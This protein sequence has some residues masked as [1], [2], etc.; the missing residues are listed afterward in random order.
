MSSDTTF[1]PRILRTRGLVPLLALM[2]LVMTGNGMVAPVL[3]LYAQQFGVSGAMVGM[4]ITLFGLGRLVANMPAGILSERHG[5]RL[6]L[7]LGPAII[8]IGALGAAVTASFAAVLAWRFVQGVG[9]GVYMTVSATVLIHLARR[10]ERGRALAI[11]Q[12]SLLLGAGIGPAIGGFLA[13]RWGL[14]MPFWAFAA[15]GLAGFLFALLVFE[16][17]EAPVEEEAAPHQGATSIGGLLMQLPFLVLCFITFGTFFTRTGSQWVTI[18]LIGKETFGLSVDVIGVALSVTSVA[19]FLMLPIVGP[20][21]DWVGARQVTVYS[22]LLTGLALALIALSHSEF[23]FWISMVLLG[24]AAG[25]NGP[26]VAAALADLVPR[27]LYGPAIGV[28]RAV[29]DVGYVLAPFL[30][31]ML[32]DFPAIGHPGALIFNAILMVVSGAVFAVVAY[33]GMPGGR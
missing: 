1:V 28:Q 25:F 6:F 12:A 30:A 23:A 17:P 7:C 8:G 29:G 11:Y 24:I 21:I 18:P 15:V 5:R 22:T 4:M 2:T 33:R 16:E 13:S 14:A 10:N 31:G 9:S 32:S 19:N 20:A 3:S 27:G 26:S